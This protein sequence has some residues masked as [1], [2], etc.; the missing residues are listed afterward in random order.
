[1]AA[2]LSGS[3]GKGNPE[4]DHHPLLHA[5]SSA[6]RIGAEYGEVS[7]R[8]P[9]E[10]AA[11]TCCVALLQA[12]RFPHSPA[13][14]TP[15]LLT[16]HPRPR[17]PRPRR[18][19]GF[20]QFRLSG[21][22]TRLD[23]E[24]LNEQLKASGADRIRHSM[25]P[26]EAFGAIFQLDNVVCQTRALQ[27][28]AW[29]RVGA[30]E[31]LPFPSLDRPQ[32]YEVPPERAAMHVLQWTRDVR[33]AR[34]LAW[35]VAAAYAEELR[36]VEAPLPGVREWLSLMSKTNV[37]CALVTSLDRATAA[38]LLE[39]LALRPFFGAMVT[40]EDDMD[41]QAQRLLSAAIKLARP[42]EQCVVFAACPSSVTAAHNCTMRAV[43]LMG[44]HTAPALRAADLTIGGLHEL[45]VY[46]LRRLFANR[47]A[48]FM[49]LRQQQAG[50]K[51]PQRRMRNA[52]GEGP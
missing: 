3:S 11:T 2:S 22:H 18:P 42:P 52:T 34:A 35:D 33:R 13:P 46:N 38:A 4:R 23:V 28:R 39:R 51:P 8:R 5:L 6:E 24:H 15:P 45:T 29:Q 21:D 41:T 48:E 27:K 36:A 49:D 1:V 10:A 17:C 12:N 44:P 30:A 19:Q 47:G 7:A 37:P 26:D 16:P 31:G 20:L 40:A 50:Q 14:L 9:R 43:A 32:L 25:R